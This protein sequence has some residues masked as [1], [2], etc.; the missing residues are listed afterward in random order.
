MPS[1]FEPCGL[2]QMYSL[3]YGTVPIVRAVGGLKDTVVDPE[4]APDTATGFVF[5][6]PSGEA[7]LGCI[8]RALLAY[9]ECP[10]TFRA[11]QQKGMHTRFTWQEAAEQYLA[12]YQ[13]IN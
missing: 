10:V 13:S 12:L 6:E 4:Y 7:L 9:Y 1:Q 3:A 5:E 8:R 11:M 2:N